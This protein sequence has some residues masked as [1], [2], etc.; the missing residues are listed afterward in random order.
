MT[1]VDEALL[2]SKEASFAQ[3]VRRTARGAQLAFKGLGTEEM[4]AAVARG[5]LEGVGGMAVAGALTGVIAGAKSLYNAAAKRQEF[6][7]ML[8][9]DVE[10]GDMYAENPTQFNRAYNS[11]RHINPIFGRDPI[12]A[13]SFMRRM[14]DVPAGAGNTLVGSVRPP[15]AATDKGLGISVAGQAGPLRFERR[16]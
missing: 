14:M 16:F 5:A 8:E 7:E 2:A 10:L 15:E 6:K 4:G 11:L 9:T 12:V 13:A 1:P 3:N